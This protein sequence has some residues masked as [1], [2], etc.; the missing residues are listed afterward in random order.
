M[1]GGRWLVVGGRWLAVGGRWQVVS[2]YGGGGQTR[3][4]YI[5]SYY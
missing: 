5:N 4:D 2:G 3:G 1:V